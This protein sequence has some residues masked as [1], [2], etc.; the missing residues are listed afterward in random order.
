MR[1]GYEADEEDYE[2]EP[3]TMKHAMVYTLRNHNDGTETSV[4]EDDATRA[5][6][7]NRERIQRL[8]TF[9]PGEGSG[10][11]VVMEIPPVLR[12]LD[13]DTAIVTTPITPDN[14]ATRAQ[15]LDTLRITLE[16]QQKALLAEQQRMFD[17]QQEIERDRA[18][19]EQER[20]TVQNRHEDLTAV[21]RRRHETRVTPGM[22]LHPTR[23]NFASPNGAPNVT[24][25]EPAPVGIGHGIMVRANQGGNGVPPNTRA[26]AQQNQNTAAA[27]GMPPP[28]DRFHTPSGHYSNPADNV[29]AA[30]LALCRMPIDQSPEGEEARRAI[31]MLKTAIT[32]QG[33]MPDKSGALHSTPY[34]S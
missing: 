11:P 20:I 16:N 18:R 7:E 14:A 29:Y 34:N 4:S 28:A 21:H 2:S 23:L 30:T 19:V 5:A 24:R 27:G 32:Q 15:Q 26:G 22:T 13:F 6:R 31:E 17:E 1:F 25:P 8:T 33:N 12:P 9:Q 3:R 10:Q